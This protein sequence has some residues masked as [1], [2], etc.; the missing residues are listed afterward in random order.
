MQ[1]P[2]PSTS[3]QAMHRKTHA[4]NIDKHTLRGCTDAVPPRQDNL[5]TC[6]T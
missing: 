2:Q 4:E 6:T 3:L 1:G 5:T